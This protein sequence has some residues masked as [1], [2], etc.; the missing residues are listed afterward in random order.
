MTKRVEEPITKISVRVFSRQLES[1]DTLIGNENYKD[2]SDLIRQAIESLIRSNS[3]L[4]S[5]IK[6]NSGGDEDGNDK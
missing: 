3:L 5:R 1:M 6:S 2:R 4:Q